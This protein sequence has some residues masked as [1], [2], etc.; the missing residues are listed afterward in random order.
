M[1]MKESKCF[2]CIHKCFGENTSE[3]FHQLTNDYKISVTYKN[4]E[5]IIKQ[6]TLGNYIYVI[7]DGFAKT[8]IESE[9]NRKII[10]NLL[11]EGDFIG[12][13]ML[14]K[15]SNI[16]KYGATAVSEVVFCMIDV[17]KLK[18]LLQEDTQLSIL[19]MD[20]IIS[21]NKLMYDKFSVLGTRNVHGRLASSLIY[22]SKF[23][24]QK[25][26]I[27]HFLQRKDIAEMSYMSIESVNKI[28]TE[29]KNEL[30]LKLDNKN[31]IIQDNTMLQH[32]AK[33]G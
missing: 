28:L 6:G 7:K 10:I 3:N 22:L 27:Y 15:N 19:Y 11:N 21:E 33:Y 17:N 14:E 31:I 16:Y 20:K 30:I 9:S 5:Q 12:L 8:T 26:N 1:N 24:N 29:L 13:N 4:G 32:L 25:K 23:N 18:K 2:E